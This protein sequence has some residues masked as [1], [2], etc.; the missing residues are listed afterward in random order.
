MPAVELQ[1]SEVR[2]FLLLPGIFCIVL[3]P[4]F[5][6]SFHLDEKLDQVS[7]K[8]ETSSDLVGDGANGI[9]RLNAAEGGGG[10]AWICVDALAA[11]EESFS[12]DTPLLLE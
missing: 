8:N 3:P 7:S 2:T 11:Q 1:H 5:P 9:K 4:R 6:K 10:L 12:A